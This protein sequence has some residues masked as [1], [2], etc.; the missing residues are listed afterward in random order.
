MGLYRGGGELYDLNAAKAL[1]E[2]GVTVRFLVGKPWLSP[3]PHPV[4]QFPVTYCATPYLRGLA[5]RLPR[6]RPRVPRPPTRVHHP[7]TRRRE[8]WQHDERHAG[9]G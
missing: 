3:P 5:N 1:Q 4:D 2:A 9:L 6:A 7:T 8:L